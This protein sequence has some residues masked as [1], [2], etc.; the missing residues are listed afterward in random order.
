EDRR[1]RKLRRK[2]EVLTRVHVVTVHQGL[3]D[4]R[5]ER[6]GVVRQARWTD[7]RDR[8]VHSPQRRLRE[9]SRSSTTICPR[10]FSPAIGLMSNRILEERHG[11]HSGCRRVAAVLP[12]RVLL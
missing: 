2:T 11:H 5:E 4:G 7:E 6:G 8:N 3:P 9:R 12:Y 1:A 10:L